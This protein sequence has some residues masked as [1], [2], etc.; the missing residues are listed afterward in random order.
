[1]R[2]FLQAIILL[3]TGHSTTADSQAPF[4]VYFDRGSSFSRELGISLLDIFEGI[5]QLRTHGKIATPGEDRPSMQASDDDYAENLSS[6]FKSQVEDLNNELKTHAKDVKGDVETHIVGMKRDIKFQAEHL[7]TGLKKLM[8]GIKNKLKR[9][10]REIKHKFEGHFDGMKHRVKEQ[11]EGAQTYLRWAIITA[12]LFS[13]VMIFELLRILL[14]GGSLLS[15]LLSR[16]LRR[17]SYAIKNSR[18]TSTKSGSADSVSDLTLNGCD[19]IPDEIP[20]LVM[21]HFDYIPV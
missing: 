19:T 21:P 4:D 8:Q 18:T 5:R 12:L 3:A 2:V 9:G 16:L 10:G 11:V 20:T 15:R 7:E 14:K 17:A 6:D 1:M 13:S